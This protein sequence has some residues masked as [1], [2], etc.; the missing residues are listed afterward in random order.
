MAPNQANA[1]LILE[2]RSSESKSWGS[3]DASVLR[4]RHGEETYSGWACFEAGRSIFL[5]LY[6]PEAIPPSAASDDVQGNPDACKI[7][8]LATLSDLSLTGPTLSS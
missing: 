3:G 5:Y 4:G 8:L 7:L 1:T 6:Q 2:G